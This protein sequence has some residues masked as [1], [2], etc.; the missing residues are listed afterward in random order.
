MAGSA[1]EPNALGWVGPEAGGG[2]PEAWDSWRKPVEGEL[3][4]GGNWK[5]LVPP[6]PESCNSCPMEW[7]LPVGCKRLQGLMGEF[8]ES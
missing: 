3:D 7:G 4:E 6:V 1:E 5:W 2:P 8:E